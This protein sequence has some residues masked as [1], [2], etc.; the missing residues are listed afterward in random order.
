M[1][2]AAFQEKN[3]VKGQQMTLG[4]CKRKAVTSIGAQHLE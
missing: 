4:A 2:R 3:T 1:S